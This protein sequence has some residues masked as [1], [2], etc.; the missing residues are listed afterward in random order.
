MV[1]SIPGTHGVLDS[2]FSIRSSL[3]SSARTITARLR[4][5][6]DYALKE[7]E[8]TRVPVTD[9]GATIDLTVQYI[10]VLA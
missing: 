9:S 3:R 10:L 6:V 7:E 1:S 5:V 2:Y 8:E 4:S